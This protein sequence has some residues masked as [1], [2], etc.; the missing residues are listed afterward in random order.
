MGKSA[1]SNVYVYRIRMQPE[2]DFAP[3]FPGLGCNGELRCDTALTRS[4]PTKKKTA[5]GHIADSLFTALRWF[6]NAP[7]PPVCHLRR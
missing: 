3:R 2:G 1:T 5:H 7:Q 4:E 6:A